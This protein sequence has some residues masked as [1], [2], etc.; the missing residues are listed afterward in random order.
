MVIFH[1]SNKIM[2]RIVYIY[3]GMTITSSCSTCSMPMIDIKHKNK[4]EAVPLTRLVR[5]APKPISQTGLLLLPSATASPPDLS[6][7]V[8]PSPLGSSRDSKLAKEKVEPRKGCCGRIMCC[9]KSTILLGLV[10][11]TSVI[12]YYLGVFEPPVFQIRDSLQNIEEIGTQAIVFAQQGI[13]LATQALNM[14]KA[15]TPQLLSAL[16]AT[17]NTCQEAAQICQVAYRA[18]NIP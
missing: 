10:C 17:R 2:H 9:S 8:P 14:V 5:V 3:V 12:A 1:V 13:G 16:N 6:V 11:S 4:S 18:C 7:L 15:T